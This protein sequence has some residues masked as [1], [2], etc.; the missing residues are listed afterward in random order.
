MQQDLMMEA[1]LIVIKLTLHTLPSRANNAHSMKI[2]VYAHVDEHFIDGRWVS[3]IAPTRCKLWHKVKHLSP[4]FPFLFQK[5]MWLS[6]GRKQL[7]VWAT[8]DAAL[9]FF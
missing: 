4:L 2:Q 5:K 6:R 7:G 8:K 1:A 3:R 9:K